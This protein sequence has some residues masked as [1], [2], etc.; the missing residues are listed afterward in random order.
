LADYHQ[1][2]AAELFSHLIESD[3][4]GDQ[5]DDVFSEKNLRDAKGQPLVT[6][7]GAVAALREA[8]GND[9]E[10]ARIRTLIKR[11]YRL[12]RDPELVRAGA[13]LLKQGKSIHNRMPWTT[14]R[15]RLSPAY[16]LDKIM[17]GHLP[18]GR[19]HVTGDFS[20]KNFYL[21][22][23]ANGVWQLEIFDF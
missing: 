19:E 5:I 4:R 22:K 17:R 13:P 7:P 18:E 8:W 3:I 15:K 2:R 23:D 16:I 11:L 20:H 21:F 1:G 12:S 6:S 10:F 14:G 9:P